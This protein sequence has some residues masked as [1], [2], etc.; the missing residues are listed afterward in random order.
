MLRVSLHHFL[1]A[2]CELFVN[3]ATCLGL[4]CWAA[5]CCVPAVTRY[6]LPERHTST[7]AL[8]IAHHDS[9]VGTTRLHV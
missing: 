9:T 3:S 8:E 2:N 6:E 4:L 5:Y 7:R 1:Q